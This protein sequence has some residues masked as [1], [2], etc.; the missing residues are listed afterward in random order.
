M[1]KRRTLKRDISYIAGELFTEVL[2]A[3]M[4]VSKIDQGAADIVLTRI[5]DMQDEYIKRV[6]HPGGKDNKKVVKAYYKKLVTDLQ[7][8][9]EAIL[10][11]I[12]ELSKDKIA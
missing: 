11:A 7:A 4:L 12:E 8:E 1:A 2:V 6:S 5:L 9:I 10:L 3:K